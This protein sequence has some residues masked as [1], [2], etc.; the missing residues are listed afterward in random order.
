MRRLVLALTLLWPASAIA[1]TTFSVATEAQLRT[2]IASATAGDSIVLTADVTLTTGELPSISTDITI[3]GGGH[4][5]SGN[6]QFRGL[7]VAAFGGASAPGPV[8]VNVTIQ[9][10]TI[11][12][13]LALGGT[14]GTGAAGGGGGG[15]LGGGLFV[16]NL[17]SVVLKDV[18]F[19]NNNATGGAG[20]AVVGATA[21]GG[22]GGIGGNG[23]DGGVGFGG[24]GGGAGLG[25]N[26]GSNSL[27]KDGILVGA[28]SGGL[29]GALPGG[30][31]GGGGASSGQGAGGGGDS[32]VAGVSGSPG[33]GGYGGGGGGGTT[34]TGSGFGGLGG[35]GG[36]NVGGSGLSGSGG[37]AGGAGGD[38][39]NGTAAS[40]GVAGGAGGGSAGPGGGGGGALGGGI[41]V[42]FGGAISISGSVTVNG[43]SVTG[44][45]GA[46]AG[47]DGSGFGAGIYFAGFGTVTFDSGAGQTQRINDIVDEF[48]ATLVSDAPRVDLDKTGAGTLV[49]SGKNLYGGATTIIA[50][51]LSVAT[52]VNLGSGDVAINDGARLAVTGS[53]TF[54]QN[55]TMAGNSI[56]SVAPGQSSIFN[57]TVTDDINRF[58]IL[59][60]LTLTGGG[61]MTLNNGLNTYTLGTTIIG[62]STL[63]VYQDGALGN[64]TSG[65]TLGDASSRGTLRYGDE[66]SL[67]STRAYTLGAAGGTIDTEGIANIGIASA[68][69]GSGGLT[70]SGTGDLTLF[71]ANTYAGG[72]RVADGVLHAG[73]GDAFGTGAM[74]VDAAGVFDLNGFNQKVGSLSGAGTV[75][76]GAATLNAGSDNTSTLFAGVISGGGSLVKNGSG[77]LTLTGANKYTGGTFVNAGT[78]AGTT[79]ALQGAIH[80]NA[81]VVF[82]QIS[83]GTYA[84]VIDGTGTL[85]KS[86]SGTVTLTGANSYSGGTLVTG[87]ALSGTTATLQGAITNNSVVQFN[88]AGNGTY[89]GDMNG[90]GTLLKSGAGVLTLTGANSYRGGT[91][92]AGGTLAGDTTSIQG[93]ILNDGQL[94]FTQ[95]LDGL[96]AGTVVGSGGVTK[97]G[98]GTLTLTGQAAYTGGTTISGGALVGNTLNLQGAIQDNAALQFNQVFDGIFSGSISGTGSLTKTGTGLVLLNG[99]NSYAGGTLVSAGGL[100]G[101]TASLQGT[102]V[103]NGLVEFNQNANGT[104]A[105]VMSGTGS[106]TKSG[107]GTLTLSATNSY[108]GGTTIAGGGAISIASNLNLGAGTGSVRLGD[109]T[110]SGTLSFTN[111]TPLSSGRNFS[112]GGG[113]GVFN[114][115]A[116]PVTLF[117]TI[118]G[119]GGL[120]KTGSGILELAGSSSYTGTTVITAGTLRA[121]AS[122][123]FGNGNALSVGAGSAVDLNGFSTSIGALSGSG[124]L[125]LGSGTLIAGVGGGSGLFSGRI[126]GSGSLVK[127]GGG[128]L[129]LTGANTYS[130]GTSVLGGALIG[131]TTSLQG[132]IVNNALVQFDQLS[133]GTYAGSMS[134]SGVL[135]KTGSGVLTLAGTNTY[136]GG[137][138]ING[139]SIIGTAGSLHGIIVN[140]AQLTFGGGSDG[141]FGGTVAGTGTVLKTGTGTLAL[142]G[143][144]T[145]TGLFS[146]GQGTLVLNG[147]YAGSIDVASGATLRAH[148]LIGG[149]LNLAG[150]LFAV[151]A[152][153]ATAFS[154]AGLTSSTLAAS[155]GTALE[156][157]AFLTIGQNLIA[158]NGSLLNFA[159]DAGTTPTLMVGG[160]AALNG[161][162]L[163]VTAPSIG[164]ARSQS[165]LAIAA[166]NGL[167]LTNTEVTSADPGVVPVLKQDRNFLFVTMVNLKVPLRSVATPRT[168]AIA[169]A[170]DRT[171]FGAT[172]D[173]AFVVGELTTLDD[174]HLQDALEQV[175]GQLHASVLQTAIL[176]SE[177]VTDLIRDQLSA[178]EL[179]E[180]EDFRWWG[181]TACQH[182]DFKA[183]DRARGG[184]ANVCAGAGGADKRLSQRWT[185]G[186]G[187]SFTGGNMGIGAMGSGDYTAP[188]AFGYVGYKPAR[189]GVRGGGSAAKSNYKTERQI[190]FQALLPVEFGA[191]PL[192]DGVDRKAEAEQQGSTSDQ[193]SEIHDSRNVRTYT[194]E[195]LVGIRHA[196]ISRGSFTESGAIA[197]DLVGQD[198]TLNLTQ[199]DVKIHGFRR[200]GAVRPFFDLSYRRELAEGE[201]QTPVRFSGLPQSDFIV[202]GLNIPASSYSA[203]GGMTFATWLGQATFTYEYKQS[204]GARRQTAGLRIR[205]K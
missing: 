43:N 94:L 142:N 15:G 96:Y 99:A 168:V 166:L 72:T 30:L 100:I 1:Q 122:N 34:G 21:G 107:V 158:T 170:I 8:A 20:G 78:L 139:G 47:T 18:N 188:R 31:N 114:T 82:D 105:G 144:N 131:D 81:A 60:G 187:G 205:F 80:D 79:D 59:G 141:L 135:A 25:A 120:T 67:L 161:S 10:L 66:T 77:V 147:S 26:G 156:G 68:I 165:F 185:F 192:S 179:D 164:T 125:F 98:T 203:R 53:D 51:T 54:N 183:N 148:G 111:S 55:L 70:K 64:P 44:G 103:N 140:N 35:G 14:G 193:W 202:E 180:G 57:G 3:D 5:L 127:T 4:T 133:S 189:F 198:E 146:V 84:G 155:S 87:G 38:D 73:V 173:A 46:G 184:S 138:L 119:S 153:A 48:G 40:G 174:A 17:A 172:G 93:D 42:D 16:A 167:Q 61:T 91:W 123:A 134:G 182:A 159:I 97:I 136:S 177:S 89:A 204:P 102:I 130:G 199:T 2:A 12:N 124:S 197:L 178:R 196:R 92:I 128:A 194:I 126:S 149:S 117:G 163:S 104:Y 113:G 129:A 33:S 171:K 39:T 56:V 88:Q 69:G 29:S 115:T 186:F 6:D 9:N 160:I 85:T 154:P 36:G 71:G 74:S 151:P 157:P 52:S 200:S 176:D 23:G 109:L 181:E 90:A 75:T 121:G 65:I 24:G 108:S 28:N 50:G 63:V 132:N 95:N 83:N 137:T 49:L 7:L 169:D 162:R 110:S 19:L 145:D 106:L 118:S 32:G 45:R 150:S 27:G 11:A 76:L 143:Q 13:T 86:G 190:Q 116:G 41:F 101:T 112:L 37:Y 62:G 191:Q 195:G 22:G 175:G 152:G 58:D 201:T